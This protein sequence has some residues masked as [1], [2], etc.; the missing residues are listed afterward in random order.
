VIVLSV[1]RSVVWT[2]VVVRGSVD[3]TDVADIVDVVSNGIFSNDSGV[4]TI[5]VGGDDVVGGV[6]ADADVDVDVDVDAD[7]DADA[8]VDVDVD[9]DGD[10]DDVVVVVVGG[11]GE[12]DGVDVGVGVVV[13]VGGIVASE[14]TDITS[15]GNVSVGIDDGDS[16]GNDCEDFPSVD[17]TFF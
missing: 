1:L 15:D 4:G 10:D 8:D 3:S 12:G 16:G 13:E 11:G 7:A 2:A 14:E 9:V 6:D 5:V 17:V